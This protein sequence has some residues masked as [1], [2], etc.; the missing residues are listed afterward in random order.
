MAVSEYPYLITSVIMVSAFGMALVFNA[1]HRRSS[2]VSAALSA[3]FALSSVL[4]VPE[5][6]NPHRIACWVAGPEDFL[7]SFAGG[8]LVWLLAVRL[9]TPRPI[10]SMSAGRIARRYLSFTCGFFALVLLFVN[11]LDLRMMTAVVA[12][13]AMVFALLLAL[14]PDL[15]SLAVRVGVVYS[16]VYTLFCA[17]AYSAFPSFLDHW[18]T[19]NL[20][21]W[22]VLSVPIE[23]AVW[24]L[25]FATCWAIGMGYAFDAHLPRGERTA[26]TE[27]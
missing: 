1:N 2:L 10:L 27:T 14:R 3:P 22:T 7:F 17:G 18:N 8:G 13:G 12:S 6:W 24:A 5:Y 26:V 23:E 16:I 9:A 15:G 19:D 25:V 4:F 21:G 20:T 11:L